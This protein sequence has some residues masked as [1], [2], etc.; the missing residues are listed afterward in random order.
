MIC[1]VV[2]EDEL[3]LC[4]ELVC[5]LYQVWLE[6]QIVVECEDGVS[7]LEVIVE[8][9][10]EVVFFD[11]CMLGFIGMDVVV[12]VVISSFGMQI[13]F[14][15]VYY[16]YVIDVFECGVIDYLFKLV[17]FECFVVIVQCIQ[18]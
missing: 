16:Q 13:V 5:L 18:L 3:L 2:V 10:L 17:I 4:D 15:I 1:V 7:V 14:I 12:V 9:Q 6:L 11:I 8:Q